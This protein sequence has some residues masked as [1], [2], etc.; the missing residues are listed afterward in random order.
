M[1]IRILSDA[2]AQP[3]GDDSALDKSKAS[4]VTSLVVCDD[5]AALD[6]SDDTST[7]SLPHNDPS[8]PNINTI[9]TIQGK[10][11]IVF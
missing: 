4:S 2:G 1:V 6:I 11:L 5:H 7:T 9:A 8:R 10:R 3:V